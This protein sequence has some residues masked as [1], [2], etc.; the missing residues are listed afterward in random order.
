M[1]PTRSPLLAL[2]LITVPIAAG[3]QLPLTATLEARGGI[4]MP[5]G[6]FGSGAGGPGARPGPALG[7]GVLVEP[8][9]VL[10][11]YGGFQ[12]IAF[13]CSSCAE[14]ALDDALSL[15]GLEA[16]AQLSPPIRI[17]G[18]TPWLR[19][20]ILHQTL[21]FAGFGERMTSRRGLDLSVGSGV[22]F[23]VTPS[24]VLTPGVRFSTVPAE[25]GFSM[26]PD[27]SLNATHLSIDVGLG[28]RFL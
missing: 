17:A 18:V 22:T 25:F 8:V 27:R 20:G 11:L 7:I 28:L 6:G 12:R 21:G 4:G 9:A 19:A 10:G 14:L 13:G 5:T 24:I 2:L 3:A 1:I 16:G 23:A 26:L 15:V